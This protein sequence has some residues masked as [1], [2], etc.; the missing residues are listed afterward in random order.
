MKANVVSCCSFHGSETSALSSAVLRHRQ[1]NNIKY[2]LIV[3]VDS[4]LVLEYK[5][6]AKKHQQIR[7][8]EA[9][10]TVQFVRNKC[11]RFWMDS[12]REAS[13]KGFDLNK[14]ST[15]LRKEFEFVE[16]LNSMAVQASA[17]RARE[18]YLSIL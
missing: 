16:S 3:G 9:I 14:Y 15:Q 8:E 2:K 1:N 10:R 6:K 12:P 17:E 7:I 11:L 13:I 5:I 4:M 18:G